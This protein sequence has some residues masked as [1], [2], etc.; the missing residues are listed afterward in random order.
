MLNNAEDASPDVLERK[1]RLSLLAKAPSE[2]LLRLWAEWLDGAQPPQHAA[3]RGPDVGAVMVRGR[4]GAIGAPFNLGEMTVARCTVRLSSGA[5][6][7]GHVQ[8]RNTEA[9]RV[10]ALVD[11][12]CEEGQGAAMEDAILAPLRTASDTLKA[13]RAAKAAATKVEFFTMVRGEGV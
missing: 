6:G 5:V 7:H 2:E 12:L 10:A 4:A 3:L 9:A 1:A 13:E 8:G 11:A